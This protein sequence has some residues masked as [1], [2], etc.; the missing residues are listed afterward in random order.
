M[1]ATNAPAPFADLPSPLNIRITSQT[2]GTY[3]SIGAMEW[4]DI[5]PFAVLTGANGVGKSQL[6]EF[7]AHKLMDT[8]P[9][10]RGPLFTA[11]GNM[12]VETNDHFPPGSVAYV[13][14][15]WDLGGSPT[16][17]IPELRDLQRE[18]WQIA[19]TTN[20]RTVRQVK[21]RL[22][23]VELALGY[24]IAQA[25]PE[26]LATLTSQDLNFLL[27][28]EDVIFGLAYSTGLGAPNDWRRGRPGRKFSRSLD[29]RRG[30]S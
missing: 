24:P 4:N 5:P 23:R 12:G 9:T 15:T 1:S 13:P 22:D 18:I 3:K 28:S 21:A 30:R 14:P 19:R 6:L 25:G 17:G 8:V 29:H 27:D 11:L 16:V 7:L 2:D 26:A 10:D 20:I